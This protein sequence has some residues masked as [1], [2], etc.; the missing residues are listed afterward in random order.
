VAFAED[1]KFTQTKFDVVFNNELL[2]RE[3]WLI[4]LKENFACLFHCLAVAAA[5]TA[6]CGASC[7]RSLLSW[8]LSVERIF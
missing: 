2:S 1:A 7:E 6:R 5:L 8:C 4:Y 3:S